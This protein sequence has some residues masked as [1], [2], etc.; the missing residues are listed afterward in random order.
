M[1][2]PT[3]EHIDQ[4][5]TLLQYLNSTQNYK[6]TYKK[7][8]QPVFE[9]ITD[10]AK[11]DPDMQHLIVSN[12]DP[13]K[14]ITGNDIYGLTDADYAN[15][16]EDT[17]KSTSGF[18]FYFRHNLVCW[19]SKLQPILATSTHEAEL[20]A[21]HLTSQ[22]AIWLRNFIAEVRSAMTGETITDLID[23]TTDDGKHYSA[24]IPTQI[25]CDNLGAV[26]T[27]TNPT[28]GKRSKHIDVRY[29]KIRE[30]LEQQRTSVKHVD[31][32]KN[33]A[34]VFTKPL[35]VEAFRNYVDL[36]GVVGKPKNSP[37]NK[38]Q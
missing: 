6:L 24:L 1:H 30:Y 25:F 18:C 29:L 38:N 37:K 9:Q 16:R 23:H 7:T 36:V 22:E 32:K 28:S 3:P 2:N 20:I 19:K 17:L 5:I 35:P 15:M 21:M 10:Y 11:S 13:T 34:D 8:N 27:A 14:P 26:H 4:L 31:G 33:I 12:Y